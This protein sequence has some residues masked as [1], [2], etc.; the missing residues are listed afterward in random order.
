[1]HVFALPAQG[2]SEDLVALNKLL[3]SSRVTEVRQEFVNAGVNSFWA[4]SV[5]TL[6][7]RQQSVLPA[8]RVD[9][10]EIL[11]PE[12]FTVFVA[13]RDCRKS[14]ADELG[15]PVYSIFTNEQLAAMARDRPSSKSAMQ[16]IPGI[17]EARAKKYSEAFLAVIQEPRRAGHAEA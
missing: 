5:T 2:E 7:T 12:D 4:V 15:V 6:Q 1:M 17:G 3:A 11:T 8:K 14:L 16:G 13:L 9:Y 10:K